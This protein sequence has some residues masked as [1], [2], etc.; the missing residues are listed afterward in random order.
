MFL[1]TKGKLYTHVYPDQLAS[2]GFNLSTSN[3]QVSHYPMYFKKNSTSILFVFQSRRVKIGLIKYYFSYIHRH[4]ESS[5]SFR[6]DVLESTELWCVPGT[7]SRNKSRLG[8]VLTT[9]SYHKLRS[10]KRTRSTSSVL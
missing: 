7:C 1:D 9:L 5:S 10:E 2:T 6:L 4:R 8:L 3:P